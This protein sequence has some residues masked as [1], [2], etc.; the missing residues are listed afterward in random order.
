MTVHGRPPPS[1]FQIPSPT[2]LDIVYVLRQAQAGEGEEE[3]VLISD[4]LTSLLA[5]LILRALCCVLSW[6]AMLWLTNTD[7][8]RGI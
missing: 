5:L 4:R 6:L 1:V 2:Q 8:L 7:R 3:V